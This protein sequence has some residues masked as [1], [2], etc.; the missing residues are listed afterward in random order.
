MTKRHAVKVLLALGHLLLVCCGAARWSPLPRDSGAR[1][2]VALYGEY[3][4]SSNSYG[5]FAPGVASQ[6]DVQFSIYAEGQARVEGA[7]PE[8]NREVRLRVSTVLGTLAQDRLREPL[9]ASL[10]A[11]CFTE[12]P[13][14][15]LVNAHVRALHLPTM[16]DY[17]G[18]RRPGWVTL[19]VYSF[20]R[21]G[22]AV[23]AGE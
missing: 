7:M 17:R 5:F 22:D 20:T 4:G 9:A 14:A 13:E 12:H 11:R 8:A 21:D 23:P 19:S 16:A 2:A 10:A 1:R 3:T 6:W 15:R 18:G